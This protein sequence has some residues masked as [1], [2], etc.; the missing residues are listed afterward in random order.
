MMAALQRVE[1]ENASSQT[2]AHAAENIKQGAN[3]LGR[4]A[5]STEGLRATLPEELV[6]QHTTR[7]FAREVVA[8]LGCVDPKG[9]GWEIDPAYHERCSRSD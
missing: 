1:Q 7:R 3:R 4:Q 8:W 6:G 5:T 9:R 2:M